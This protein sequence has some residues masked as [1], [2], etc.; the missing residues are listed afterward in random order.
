ME[1][2]MKRLFLASVAAMTAFSGGAA[3]S[4]D[5][6]VKVAGPAAVVRAACAQFG[7][8]YLGAH[9]GWGYYGHTWS[10]RDAWTSELSD[11]LQ[12]S[13]VVARD[14]GFLGGA[15]LGYNWQRGCTLFGVEI[16]Y[17][18][19][20]LETN[21]RETDSDVGINTDT[22]TVDSRLRGLGSLKTRTGV[23]VDNLLIYV[24]GGLALGNFSRSYSQID[25]N[26]P[27]TETFSY[28]KT[29]WGWLAGFGTE[30]A[31]T[32]NWSFKSEVLYIQFQSDEQT[33]LCV[34]VITCGPP[35][36]NKRFG[37]DDSIWTTKFA[38]NYRWGGR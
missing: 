3:I 6:P 29:K 16:D 25:L 9:A 32:D 34:A 7:G 22:L 17:A 31:I 23:I 15:Q 8:L 28:S 33:F 11:D 24:T 35:G 19:A 27:G 20:S 12:R 21:A 38:L 5:M 1:D 26:T 18:W 13:N 36:E 37:H 14:S 10:D 2:P 4:A 30:W